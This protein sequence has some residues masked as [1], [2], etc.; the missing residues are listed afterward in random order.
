MICKKCG[1]TIPDGSRFCEKCGALSEE[2]PNT[3][4]Q[5]VQNNFGAVPPM[6]SAAAI[7]K[8][9]SKLKIAIIIAAAVILLIIIVA[10]LSGEDSGSD[11][12]VYEGD[13]D[14]EYIDIV[15]TGIPYA[16]PDQTWGEELDILCAD[17]GDWR[18]FIS[19]DEERLVEF[20]G[21]ITDTGEKLCIQWRCTD[22]EDDMVEFEIR[23]I[24]ID[25]E[26]YSTEEGI[27]AMIEY[28]F[29]G[30]YEYEE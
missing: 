14:T 17:S 11:D 6:N 7:P 1:Q 27:D 12:K 16:Y 22:E 28:V 3:Y 9:K 29:E 24:E 2:S 4:A 20:N 26:N 19:T 21:V 8:K 10:A 5:P 18:T 25:G 23:Y 13:G 15:K 30:Q